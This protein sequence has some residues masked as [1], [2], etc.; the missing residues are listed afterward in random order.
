MRIV[1]A[2]DSAVIR[3]GLAEVLTDRGHEVVAAR[4]PSPSGQSA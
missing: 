2:E 3:A 4:P 1:I